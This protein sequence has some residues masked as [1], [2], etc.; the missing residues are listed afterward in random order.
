MAIS[1]DDIREL[2]LPRVAPRTMLG[3]GL[4]A[5]AALLVLVVTR[6]PATVPV[7]VAGSDLPAG[8]P[9]AELEIDTR[10]VA[11]A[12]GLVAGDSLGELSDWVLAA[13]IAAGEPLV[14]S[15]LRPSAAITAPDTMAVELEAGHAVLGRLTGGDLVDVY[16][17]TT[18]GGAP[19]ETTLIAASLYVLDARMVESNAGPDRVELLLAV[20]ADTARAITNAI[21][22]GEIDLVRIAP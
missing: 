1:I 3:V 9:L 5:V 18:I 21:H 4:A 13:P 19:A 12:D 14:P 7:L 8:T 11:S 16:A 10:Q 22:A 2:P 17:T 20:D 15:Q 6:P